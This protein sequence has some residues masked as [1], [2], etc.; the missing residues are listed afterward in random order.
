MSKKSFKIVIL[1]VALAGGIIGGVHY[2]KNSSVDT[3]ITKE[4]V[5]NQNKEGQKEELKDELEDNKKE[6]VVIEEEPKIESS[7]SKR[8]EK[9]EAQSFDGYLEESK[10]V[11]YN[12]LSS[13]TIT[14]KQGN[15]YLT[16]KSV[17]VEIKGSNTSNI[18][19]GNDNIAVSNG[20]G[21][22]SY[23]CKVSDNLTIQA[24]SASKQINNIVTISTGVDGGES[25]KRY[26]K[27]KTSTTAVL[28]G[29]IY[30]SAGITL[31]SSNIREHGVRYWRSDMEDEIYTV[32]TTSVGSA[33]GTL[34]YEVKATSLKENTTYYMQ[35]YM[36]NTAGE[37]LLGDV[38]EFA[39]R[40]QGIG[41]YG[42]YYEGNSSTPKVIKQETNP[43][44]SFENLSRDRVKWVGEIVPVNNGVMHLR[45][46]CSNATG[47]IKISNKTR[48]IYTSSTVD[49]TVDNFSVDRVTN[50]ELITNNIYEAGKR[51][52]IVMD[53]SPANSGAIKIEWLEDG[54]YREIPKTQLYPKEYTKIMSAVINTKGTDEQRIN[55]TSGKL[56][57]KK[58]TTNGKNMNTFEIG[59]SNN[60]ATTIKIN[61][62]SY[63]IGTNCKIEGCII[64]NENG[65]YEPIT[66]NVT[67]IDYTNNKVTLRNG[68]KWDLYGDVNIVG[69]AIVTKNSSGSDV[70]DVYDLGRYINGSVLSDN[71]SKGDVYRV[72]EVDTTYILDLYNKLGESKEYQNVLEQYSTMERLVEDSKPVKD[73]WNTGIGDARL[74]SEIPIRLLLSFDGDTSFT[75]S[76]PIIKISK[77]L[78]RTK[79]FRDDINQNILFKNEDVLSGVDTVF[80]LAFPIEDVEEVSSDIYADWR[81]MSQDSNGYYVESSTKN[82]VTITQDDNYIYVKL[83][84]YSASDELKNNVSGNS[85]MLNFIVRLNSIEDKTSRE[86]FDEINSKLVDDAYITY[87]KAV[88]DKM[89]NT[90]AKVVEMPIKIKIK[91]QV[92]FN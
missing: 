53:F 72:D 89:G 29:K 57:G 79:S 55:K 9:L 4:F 24:G 17:L 42:L 37:V 1:F 36:I 84:G 38:K 52:P 87:T 21:A 61:G 86:I 26:V 25:G 30:S 63:T 56:V 47:T 77:S 51:Y 11:M 3:N 15:N 59:Y 23:V 43:I 34:K 22:Y 49:S 12:A 66:Q 44:M 31:S 74:F 68:S 67:K 32:K 71:K 64:Y 14:V 88:I 50:K 33:S 8:G 81:Y 27:D 7:V 90:E 83:N 41:L 75:M 20:S 54:E 82:K 92:V 28:G 5:F 80:K 70:Y 18:K 16:N 48:N 62:T 39:T 73:K 58:V 40:G 76:E 6:D 91:P 10:G 60:N 35:A 19:I 78:Y 69:R 45:V 65:V 85:V 13:D 2:Y 46:T